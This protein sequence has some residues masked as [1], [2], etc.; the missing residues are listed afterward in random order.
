MMDFIALTVAFPG[1]L[2]VKITNIYR[3]YSEYLIFSKYEFQNLG[4]VFYQQSTFQN[5][6]KLYF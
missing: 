5:N 3:R 2:E 1:N 4:P 6:S